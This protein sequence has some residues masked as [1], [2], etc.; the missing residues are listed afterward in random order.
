[1]IYD[2][3]I[4]GGGPSGLQAAL[5]LSRV[6]RKILVFDNKQYRNEKADFL[7]GLLGHDKIK[8]E[9]L[10]QKG[11][12]ELSKYLNT[13]ILF[14]T[15]VNIV[16]ENDLFIVNSE[17]EYKTK[18]LILATGLV[19]NLP[20][21]PGLKELYGTKVE[22]CPYCKG[23]S[24]LGKNIGIHGIKGA[25]FCLTFKSLTGEITWFSD[26]KPTQ[27]EINRLT[28]YNISI[29]EDKITN[30]GKENENLIYLDGKE[31][32]YVNGLFLSLTR[33]QDQRSK[34]AEKLGL[35]FDDDHGIS[36]DGTGKTK[37]EACWV[38][39]DASKDT[40]LSAVG[41][42][43]GCSVGTKVNVYLKELEFG[44]P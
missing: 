2:C 36:H 38:I 14:E 5:T 7:S 21:I 23:V 4:I 11:R 40:L 44:K 24:F 10:R 25:E 6:N 15:V 39:G 17:K 41:I 34:L 26:G 43:E 30:I 13:E 8:P 31:R 9:E 22:H 19:D 1:M 12:N 20:N 16:K 29:I 27:E 32:Y 35:D 28:K 37:I 42:G 18:T 33:G 3:I